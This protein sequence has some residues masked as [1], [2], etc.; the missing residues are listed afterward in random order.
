MLH[1]GGQFS[2]VCFAVVH[3]CYVVKHL[4]AVKVVLVSCSIALSWQ[5]LSQFPW[6]KKKKD[7]FQDKVNT[8]II[9]CKLQLLLLEN[10]PRACRK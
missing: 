9:H 10:L 8:V 6:V 5:F 4:N 3:P 7:A 2:K 1:C